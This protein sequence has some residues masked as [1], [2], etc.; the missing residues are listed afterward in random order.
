ME[1]GYLVTNES[2]AQ[3]VTEQAFA[4]KCYT[5]N[6]KAACQ[7]ALLFITLSGQAIL[8]RVLLFAEKVTIPSPM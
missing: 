4:R 3:A 1:I 6:N 7:A 2:S 5:I 8:D